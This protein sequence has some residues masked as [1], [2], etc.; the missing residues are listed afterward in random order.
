MTSRRAR[1]GLSGAPLKAVCLWWS[2]TDATAE[3]TARLW[4]VYRRRFDV[5][6]VRLF[7]AFTAIRAGIRLPIE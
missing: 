5:E 2:G 4:Q 6:H 1:G 3:F 7:G